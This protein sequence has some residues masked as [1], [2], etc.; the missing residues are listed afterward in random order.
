ML[1]EHRSNFK[2]GFR[3]LI[4]FH[5]TSIVHILGQLIHHLVT[6]SLLVYYVFYLTLVS[7]RRF[8]DATCD[9]SMLHRFT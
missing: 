7:Y 6:D 1:V 2:V 9:L 4:G 5:V 8:A 3:P